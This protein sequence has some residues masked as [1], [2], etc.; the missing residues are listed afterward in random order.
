MATVVV[1]VDGSAC[2]EA[3]LDVAAEE[4]ALRHA[5]LL[6]VA[7]WDVQAGAVM[8]APA[9]PEVFDAFR[10]QA[11]SIVDQA[12]SRVARLHPDIDCQGKALEGRPGDVIL[13]QG[14]EAALIV[15]GRRGHGGFAGLLL[16]SVSQQVVN[17]AHRPVLVVPPPEG[18]RC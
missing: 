7:A 2:A 4:A 12:L 1:G 15:V 10:Q 8:V 13:E 5:H 14:K 17:H 11:Q 3:A 9:F 16:G 18:V 6:V